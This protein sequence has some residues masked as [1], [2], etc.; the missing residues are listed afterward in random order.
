MK[1]CVWH[2]KMNSTTRSANVNFI[3][4]Y[5][6]STSSSPLLYMIMYAHYHRICFVRCS[7]AS[8]NA[9]TH[10][11]NKNYVENNLTT[12]PEDVKNMLHIKFHE[13]SSKCV[14]R[15]CG[16]EYAR[17]QR[18]SELF[19]RRPIWQIEVNINMDE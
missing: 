17:E 18:S 1:Q 2:H 10:V 15:V 16:D 8:R 7:M 11:L 4:F 6:T 12:I 9:H 3:L 13:M 14:Y 19:I 5:P